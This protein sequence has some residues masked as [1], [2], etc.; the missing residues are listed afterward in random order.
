MNRELEAVFVEEG[1]QLLAAMRRGLLGGD[2]RGALPEL[3]RCAHML[4]GNVKLA[5][6]PEMER[7]A[8]P[9]ADALRAAKLR[10][11]LSRDEAAAVSEAVDACLD[12][13]E[14]RAAR[15][16]FA[17][18]AKLRAAAESAVPRAAKPAVKILLIEDSELQAEIIRRELGQ[19]D[20]AVFTVERADRLAAGLERVAAGGFDVVLLDLNL[21]DSQGL[22]TF[23]GLA[24]RAPSVPV[25]ILTVADDDAL[26]SA[27]L[28]QGAQDYVVKGKIGTQVLP[29]VIRY[30]IERKRVEE[31]LRKTRAE[32]ELRVEER[33]SELRKA[34][35]ELALFASAASHELRE[36]L[37]K[38]VTWSDL[39][40]QGSG[41]ALG[42]TG[43][44][45]LREIQSAARRQ[46]DLIDSLREL[47]RVTTQGRPLERVELDAVIAELR[48]E[49]APLFAQAG[50]RL[51]AERLPAVRG[52]RVQ[53][54]QLFRNLLG[55]SLKY[56]APQRP[57]VVSIRSRPLGATAFE[58]DVED[59]GIG[60]EQKYAERIFEPFQRLHGPGAYEGTGMGLAIC[61]RIVARHD[62]TLA[63][64]GEPGK[65][66]T[67]IVT[68]PLAKEAK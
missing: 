62:G 19:C 52:D 31:S 16:P 14:G 10:G 30:A 43:L 3:Y 48:A 56:R 68:L 29:R 5:G 21:P 67:F 35:R 8:A 18:A 39:L 45:L 64:R 33:T 38:I 13:L 4:K 15:A 57:P 53:M 28:R 46:A 61:A 24:A 36:P 58:I 42:E 6:Y 32:L 17:V 25:V 59:N 63:A 26:A 60:F 50:G 37:R 65:G 66:A 34:N 1:R 44:N 51:E 55:N 40:K 54:G 7:V 20:A 27:A 12:I 49:T 41:E 47:T 11:T 22:E 9:L 23:T 2:W